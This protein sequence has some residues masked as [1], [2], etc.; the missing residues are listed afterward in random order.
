MNFK[1]E[2]LPTGSFIG[3]TGRVYVTTNCLLAREGKGFRA[4]KSYVIKFI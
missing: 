4:F 1:A 3:A 2:I